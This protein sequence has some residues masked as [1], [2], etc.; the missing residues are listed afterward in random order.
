MIVVIMQNHL[1][2]APMALFHCEARWGVPSPRGQY[3]ILFS[4]VAWTRLY[5]DIQLLYRKAD[6]KNNTECHTVDIIP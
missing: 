2:F 5:F 6:N 3:I 4:Y 1:I